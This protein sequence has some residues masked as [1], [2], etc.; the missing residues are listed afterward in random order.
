[1]LLSYRFVGLYTSQNDTLISCFGT[2]DIKPLPQ[3]V[4]TAVNPGGWGYYTPTFWPGMVHRI[5][6]PQNLPYGKNNN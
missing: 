5:I 1:M 2:M 4:I 6:P 3:P